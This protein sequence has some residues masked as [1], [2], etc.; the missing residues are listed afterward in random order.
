MS[1]NYHSNFKI[2]EKKKLM[3]PCPPFALE[4]E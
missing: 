3:S 2:R 1:W 4:K